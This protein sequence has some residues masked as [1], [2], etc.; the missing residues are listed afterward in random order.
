MPYA[1][2]Q[3]L[4][5]QTLDDKHYGHQT[6]EDQTRKTR[7]CARPDLR[8][9]PRERVRVRATGEWRERRHHTCKNSIS[10]GIRSTSRLIYN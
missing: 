1:G 3:T 10:I 4:H 7:T 9:V 6:P 8:A 5:D 2:R